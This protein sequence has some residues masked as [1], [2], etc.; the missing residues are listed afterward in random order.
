VEDNLNPD[1]MKDATMPRP[2]LWLLLSG[3]S[4]SLTGCSGCNSEGV[5]TYQITNHRTSCAQ[6]FPVPSS[7]TYALDAGGLGSKSATTPSGQSS[8]VAITD[9]SSSN[10]FI[11][12][13]TVDVNTTCDENAPEEDWSQIELSNSVPN[14]GTAKFTIDAQGNLTWEIL[15]PSQV[16]L[17][18]VWSAARTAIGF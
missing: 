8:V 15:T 17:N 7:V 2:Y 16:M 9:A 12:S 5:F 10:G 6:E 11:D 13:V 3:L 1:D 14:G 4:L 18:N